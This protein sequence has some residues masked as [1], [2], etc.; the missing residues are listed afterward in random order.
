M[1]WNSFIVCI[2]KIQHTKSITS[3]HAAVGRDMWAVISTS[4]S[5]VIWCSARSVSDSY[6]SS[7]TYLYTQF[8]T[9]ATLRHNWRK[10]YAVAIVWHNL[11][12][13]KNIACQRPMSKV[14]CSHKQDYQSQTQHQTAECCHLANWI[15]W[16]Q[17]AVTDLSWKFHSF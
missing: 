7:L 17:Y 16:F 3:L 10:K 5:T 2:S 6:V 9:R 11:D 14:Y 1:R 15:A 4:Y 12:L 8:F 13:L